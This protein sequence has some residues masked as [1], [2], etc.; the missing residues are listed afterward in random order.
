MRALAAAALCLCATAHAEDYPNK[1]IRILIPF[2]AGGTTDVLA[3]VVAQQMSEDWKTQVIPD[4]HPGAN[5]IIAAEM[6]AKSP[7]DGY[8]LLF[9]AMGH[10]V[11][12]LMYKKLPYDT[13]RDFTPISLTATFAQMVLVNP[14]VPAH[15]LKELIALAKKGPK[16]LSYASG[17]IGSSQHLGGALL[18]YMAGI[19]MDHV[20]YKGGSPGLMDVIAGNVSLMVTQPTSMAFITSGKLRALAISSPTRSPKHPDLPTVAE[21]GVP[22]YQSLAWYGLVGPKNMA[23]DVLKKISEETMRATR[24]KQ[25]QEALNAQ[26][27]DAVGGTPAEFAAYIKAETNRYAKVVKEAGISAD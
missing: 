25:M 9:V 10:A 21:S 8:T 19:K 1:P 3:R 4:N 6:A 12:P 14:S 26:G 5:G 22:G 16:P 18:A 23:A 2:V 7:G 15:N 13:E 11:N 27:G 24:S 20:P 17:G